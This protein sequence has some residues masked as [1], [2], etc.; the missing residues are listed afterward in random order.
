M[1]DTVKVLKVCLAKL[2]RNM[3]TYAG[4]T[5]KQSKYLIFQRYRLNLQ[6]VISLTNEVVRK[7]RRWNTFWN[8]YRRF[9]QVWATSGSSIGAT[10][11]FSAAMAG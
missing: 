10:W 11:D 9:V 7:A 1:F 5:N 6:I 8:F 4:A 2:L 3:H